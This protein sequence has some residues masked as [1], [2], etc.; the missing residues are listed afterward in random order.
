MLHENES[1]KV[2]K[3]NAYVFKKR[4]HLETLKVSKCQSVML[5]FLKKHVL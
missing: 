2:S 4:M 5:M 1:V 3:C